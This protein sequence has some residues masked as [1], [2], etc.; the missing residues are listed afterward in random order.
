[1]SPPGPPI[2]PRNGLPG[3]PGPQGLQGLPGPPGPAAPA[4]LSTSRVDQNMTIKSQY[5]ENSFQ[6]L[7]QTM[8]QVLNAQHTNFNMQKQ[9]QH[10]HDTESAQVEVLK[11]LTH[12]NNQRSFDQVF[13]AIDHFDR[14][15][16]TKFDKLIDAL[17]M[18]CYQSG[19]NI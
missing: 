19:K 17:E 14:E 13:V 15:D 3:P 1:M 16:P 9:L 8:L 2:P 11:Q 4:I 7:S 6:V 12:V 18:A 10:V 5:L